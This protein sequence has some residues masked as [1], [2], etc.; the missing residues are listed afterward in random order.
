GGG[1]GAEKDPPGRRPR[2]P[3]QD[4]PPRDEWQPRQPRQDYGQFQ[5]SQRHHRKRSRTP[6]YAGIAAVI[7]IAA[8]GTAYALTRHGSSPRPST[9]A[10][11]ATPAPLAPPQKIAL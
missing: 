5:P 10:S 3:P 6:L 2:P 8:G 9:A 7:V 1:P 11:P 4:Y